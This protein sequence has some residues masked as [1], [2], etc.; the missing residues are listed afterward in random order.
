MRYNSLHD[1]L[2]DVFSTIPQPTNEQIKQAKKEYRKMYSAQ[3]YK[4]YRQEYIQISFRI[5]KKQF[6]TFSK[7][8]KEKNIKVT[9]LIRQGIL[10]QL[11]K[12]FSLK[13]NEQ[14]LLLLQ[15]TD[16]IEVAVYEKEP[17]DVKVLLSLL[18]QMQ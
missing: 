13:T 4:T 7:L 11:K 16:I 17:V 12:S 15:M 6:S 8:A 9:T 5:S 1:Y 14:R 3:Y 2:D 18:E 10:Q